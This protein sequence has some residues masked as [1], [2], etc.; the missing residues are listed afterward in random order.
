[1]AVLYWTPMTLRVPLGWGTVADPSVQPL[2]CMPS[3]RG[4][5]KSNTIG[6]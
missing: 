3:M 5:H 6:Q 1:M 2:Q 4:P